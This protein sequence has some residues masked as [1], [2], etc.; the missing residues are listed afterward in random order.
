MTVSSTVSS[1]SY[2]GN[3]STTVFAI[4]FGFDANADI[5]VASRNASGDVTT[6]TTGFT[7]AGAGTGSGTCTFTTAPAS[8][9]E[10]VISRAPSLLQPTDYTSNDRFP[11]ETHEAALDRGVMQAQYLKELI[12][13][14]LR[15][16][17]GDEAAGASMELPVTS[18]RLGKYLYFN[19]TTGL[20]EVA[21]LL[22]S[23][24]TLS[25]SVIGDYWRPLTTEESA[26]GLV[27]GDIYT[28]FDPGDF[29][30]YKADP[31]G[32]ADSAAAIRNA[33][34]AGHPLRGGGPTYTYRMDSEVELPVYCDLDLQGATIKPNGAVRGFVHRAA[35]LTSVVAATVN[36]G[37]TA[38]SRSVVVASA[39]SLAVGQWVAFSSND[40]GHQAGSWPVNWARITDVSGTTIE[41][42]VPIKVTYNATVTMTAYAST[43]FAG[44]AWIRNGT[45]DLVNSTYTATSG[46]AF[47]LCGY[48]LLMLD[49][50]VKNFAV[51]NTGFVA[52]QVFNCLEVLLGGRYIDGVT[53]GNAI[54]VQNVRT[55]QVPH[56]TIDGGGFG[57]NCIRCDDVQIGLL[58]IQGR[59]H[60]E[61]DETGTST[62]TRGLK[63][64]G[65]PCPQI[66]TIACHD[67]LSG[68][69][70]ESNFRGQITNFAAFNCAYASTADVAINFSGTP[71]GD[72]QFGWNVANLNV[73][74]CG[75]V[76]VYVSQADEGRYNFTNVY[77]RNCASHGMYS[78][79]VDLQIAN[80]TCENWNTGNLGTVYA[81]RAV[82]GLNLA[83][84]TFRNSDN[85]DP[86]MNSSLTAGKQFGFGTVRNPDGNP[87]FTGGTKFFDN[88]G[89]ATIASGTTSIVVNHGLLATPSINDI[90]LRAAENATTEPGTLWID[91]ITSTQFTINCRTN[92]GASNL[93]VGWRAKLP[94][95]FTA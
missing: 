81:L 86:C 67:L 49:V 15:V 32:V 55:L 52:T 60:Y 71:V 77:L 45:V 17:F 62:S 33:C 13:R 48:A 56:L 66:N 88:S 41:I 21:D 34:L 79:V 9:V 18:L 51:A 58:K 6:L 50:Q 14:A 83:N 54:D 85:T 63:F 43:T 24:T 76:G 11:A 1:I 82:D 3:G 37:A 84:A 94:A 74:G 95:P 91:T 38:G 75:G 73:D 31:T 57:I 5:A 93:D 8:G 12:D 42:D 26:A 80:F 7:V 44:T 16:P 69:K 19:G 25:R 22:T 87:L 2:A 78:E 23:G 70:I 90:T 59:R 20:P 65:C 92:P 40:A 29:R 39:T 36:S 61:Y 27:A 68:L 4:P 53:T 30:R 89:T 64:I 47:R 28:W 35:G 10:I 72:N 46:S